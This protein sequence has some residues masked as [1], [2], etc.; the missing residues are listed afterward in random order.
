MEMV[1]IAWKNGVAVVV[2]AFVCVCVC[3]CV[4]VCV[5]VCVREREKYY[6]TI[7][8]EYS[9]TPSL[10]WVRSRCI[11]CFPHPFVAYCLFE[12]H[13]NIVCCVAFTEI[14]MEVLRHI[15][16]AHSLL[17]VFHGSVV[18]PYH[19]PWSPCK[20]NVQLAYTQITTTTY[21]VATR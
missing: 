5:C 4:C 14:S 1:V 11:S 16:Y 19:F 15:A 17:E 3:A 2:C 21:F 12:L 10:R 6:H 20:R 7:G 8:V 18:I 9:K 13:L